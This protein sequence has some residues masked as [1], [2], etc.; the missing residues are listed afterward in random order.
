MVINNCKICNKEFKA[1]RRSKQTCSQECF[2]KLLSIGKIGKK[3]PKFNNG[4]RQWKRIMKDINCC[5]N[6]GRKY[7]LEVHHKDGNQKNNNRDNLM[8]VCRRCHMLIDGRLFTYN[9]NSWKYRERTISD[10]QKKI[11]SEKKKAWWEA[12]KRGDANGD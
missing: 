10:E 6:C 1:T 7:K 5:E 8:K 12:K 4:H 11:L 2:Y 9:K 3:N